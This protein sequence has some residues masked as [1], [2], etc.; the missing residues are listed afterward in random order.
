MRQRWLSP[1]LTWIIMH[2]VVKIIRQPSFRCSMESSLRSWK[3]R[4]QWKALGNLSMI[5]WSQKLSHQIEIMSRLWY[6]SPIRMQTLNDWWTWLSLKERKKLHLL[7]K[8]RIMRS[9]WRSGSYEQ[10][11]PSMQLGTMISLTIGKRHLKC[12]EKVNH[13]LGVI[14]RWTMKVWNK[15]DHRNSIIE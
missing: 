4:R 8:F 14:L 10:R 2:L 1:L 11:T 12:L 5:L 9:T 15:V 3:S 13:R 6:A 7:I